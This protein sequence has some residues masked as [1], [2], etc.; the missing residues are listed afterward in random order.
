MAEGPSAGRSHLAKGGSGDR[1]R[2]RLI[3]LIG[4]THQH[5]HHPRSRPSKASYSHSSTLCGLGLA[6]KVERGDAVGLDG[7]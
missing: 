1:A 5:G 3:L 2:R 7:G 6:G 4:A